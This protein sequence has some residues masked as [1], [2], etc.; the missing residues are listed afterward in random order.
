MTEYFGDKGWYIRMMGAAKA[1]KRIRD[2]T[3][4]FGQG[5]PDAFLRAS[6]IMTRRMKLIITEKGHV[7]T[8]TLR[9]SLHEEV[10]DWRDDYIEISVGTWVHYARK[11]EDLPDGG[12]M[13]QAFEETR[14]E[15]LKRVEL[16]LKRI[17]QRNVGR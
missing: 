2:M 1:K 8:G 10:T 16:E 3:R 9:G 6:T 13:F 5:L 11:I 7:V 15:V 12:Y 17:I 4:Q 14:G